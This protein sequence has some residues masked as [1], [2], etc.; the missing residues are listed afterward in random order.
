VCWNAKRRLIRKTEQ[1]AAISAYDKA[2]Q[3]YDRVI[4]ESIAD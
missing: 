4:Q 2:R 1:V 3:F